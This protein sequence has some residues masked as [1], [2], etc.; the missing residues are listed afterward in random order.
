[1][2]NYREAMRL[3][4][5]DP[6]AQRNLGIVLMDLGRTEEADPY[7]RRAYAFEPGQPRGPLEPG[8]A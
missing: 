8:D 3:N 1:M 4:P 6:E 2:A 5:K 7:I